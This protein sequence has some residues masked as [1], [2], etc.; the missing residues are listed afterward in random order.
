MGSHGQ[1][2]KLPYLATNVAGQEIGELFE[3]RLGAE[4]ELGLRRL[5]PDGGGRAARVAVSV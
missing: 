1:N 4:K 3:Q 5:E 2:K